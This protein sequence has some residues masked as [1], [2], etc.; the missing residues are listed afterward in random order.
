MTPTLTNTESVGKEM[1]RDM[2]AQLG[3][4]VGIP[5]NII[6]VSQNCQNEVPVIPKSPKSV[7]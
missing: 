1:P 6:G 3:S 7:S 5:K 2:M 4:L